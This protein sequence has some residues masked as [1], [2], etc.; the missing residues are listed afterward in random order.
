M[1]TIPAIT[2]T[3]EVND[4]IQGKDGERSDRES[5]MSIDYK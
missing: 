4:L 3:Y 1:F 2:G 5:L